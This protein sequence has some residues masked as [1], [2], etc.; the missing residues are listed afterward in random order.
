MI[1]S[2]QVEFL[3]FMVLY[4]SDSSWLLLFL[5]M[6]SYIFLFVPGGLCMKFIFQYK[7]V[8]R[9]ASTIRK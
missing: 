3:R 9:H 2:K 8:G 1:N 4:L 7:A 5:L 6:A